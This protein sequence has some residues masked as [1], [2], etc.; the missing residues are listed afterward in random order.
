MIVKLWKASDGGAYHWIFAETYAQVKEVMAHTLEE[1]LGAGSLDFQESMGN[2]E[3]VELMQNE[4]FKFTTASGYV[5][6]FDVRT[7]IDF[8]HAFTTMDRKP[9][10]FGCSE[11]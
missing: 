11:W 5:F 2:L 10:Y 1:Q 9:F 8:F 4:T 7:W 6:D 3:I